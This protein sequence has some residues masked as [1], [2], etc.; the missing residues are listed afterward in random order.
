MVF[1]LLGAQIIER[2]SQVRIPS[3]EFRS[4]DRDTACYEME[5]S[6]EW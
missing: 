3:L 4:G 1:I 2:L 6:I 5:A